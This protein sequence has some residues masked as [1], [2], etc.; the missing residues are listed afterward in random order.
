MVISFPMWHQFTTV[1]PKGS[2]LQILKTK[3][4]DS[5]E[6]L[7]SSTS[8]NEES[9][10]QS[11]MKKRTTKESIRN[12]MKSL[13]MVPI[14][15]K[16]ITLLLTIEMIVMKSGGIE[17]MEI[18][19]RFDR[20][21]MYRGDNVDRDM[22]RKN[23]DGGLVSKLNGV[24]D[25]NFNMANETSILLGIEDQG[26]SSKKELRIIHSSWRKG[27]FEEEC[28]KS[29]TLESFVSISPHLN[30]DVVE[31]E[32][33]NPFK[34]RGYGVTRDEHENMEIFQGPVTRLMARKIEEESSFAREEL[35]RLY[36][37][38]HSKEKM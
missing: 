5:W 17:A 4:R 20:R 34:K 29:W 37:E 22:D 21:L 33:T 30:L 31:F 38:M 6:N 19:Q 16:D 13:I 25:Y 26:K 23:C 2:D 28:R 10:L 32:K 14:L 27:V 18:N 7:S 24:H 35:S 9:I 11:R 3:G 8:P 12:T 36:V 1:H 15:L